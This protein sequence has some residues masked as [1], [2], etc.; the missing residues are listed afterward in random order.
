L[1]F[2][3]CEALSAVYNKNEMPNRI[4]AV[5]KKLSDCISVFHKQLEEISLIVT[6]DSAKM[7]SYIDDPKGLY[8]YIF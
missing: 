6:K 7:K 2:E 4:V 5:P 1:A 3:E 8:S